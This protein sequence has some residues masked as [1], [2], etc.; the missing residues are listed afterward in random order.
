MATIPVRTDQDVIT[1]ELQIAAP[2]ERIFQALTD[3]V[4]LQQ[5]FRSPECPVKFWEFDARMNGAYRYQT[6]MGNVVVNGTREFK[7]HGHIIEFDPPR[8]LAYTWYANWHD[9]STVRTVVRWELTPREGGTHVKV[10]HSGLANLPIAREDYS[11]GWPEV[12][13]Q[14][15]KFVER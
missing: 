2:P 10:T 15:K 12:V 11:G 1:A 3:P 8:V 7:C 9:D 13:E 14:L 6:E 5:W 4:Q